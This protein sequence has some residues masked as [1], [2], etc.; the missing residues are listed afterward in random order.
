MNFTIRTLTLLIFG[1]VAL[2]AQS[3]TSNSPAVAYQSRGA[4]FIATSSGHILKS[5]KTAP[6]ISTF[7]ISRDAP[8]IVF[9]PF[10]KK[11][12]SYGGQLYLLV[13]PKTM[14]IRLTH[15]PYYNKSA[16]SSEVY[17]NP[18][19]SPDGKQVVFSVHSQS[20]GDLEPVS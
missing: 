10:G 15:G 9:A 6:A 11:S 7:A 18:D 17:S 13:P 1:S 4:L 12:D 20:T 2:H 5:I 14:A 3:S 8:Q 16:G 19:F